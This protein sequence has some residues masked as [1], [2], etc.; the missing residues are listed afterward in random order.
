MTLDE[1]FRRRLFSLDTPISELPVGGYRPEGG[2]RPRPAAVLV[3]VTA[4]SD[5]RILLTV[6]AAHLA[7]HA[8]QVAFPG[9][10]RDRPGET[11]VQTALREAHEETG[12]APERVRPAGLLGRYDTITGFR[13][14]AVVG[15]IDPAFEPEPDRNEVD[16][17][18]SV[19]L[20]HILD[21]TAWRRDRVQWRQRS[22]EIL[23]LDHPEHRIWGATAA[24]LK[25][26]GERLDADD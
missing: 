2:G 10:G 3:P 23:T 7:K 24:L 14:T 11:V 21:P 15:W 16:A 6:R 22:F 8:G 19:S 12:L 26:L 5:P 25:D 13:M 9:G 1:A 20:S 18:F 17:V 4:E